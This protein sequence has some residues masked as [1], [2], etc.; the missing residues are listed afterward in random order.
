MK[1]RLV[2]LLWLFLMR[3]MTALGD[4]NER[5]ISGHLL[6]NRTEIPHLTANGKFLSPKNKGRTLNEGRGVLLI[7]SDVFG[8]RSIIIESSA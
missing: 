7:L 8:G 1:E 4:R 2:Y 5:R 3:K 6:P